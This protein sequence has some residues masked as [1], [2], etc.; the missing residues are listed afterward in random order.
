MDRSRWQGIALF[1]F[2]PLV[3]FLYLQLP[4]GP[5]LSLALG[6]GL[7]IGHRFIAAPWAS[8][9][10]EKR[11]I[12]CGR[13]GGFTDRLEVAAGKTEWKLVAC[14]PAHA[15][16]SKQFFTFIDRRK[17]W[18]A[19]GIFVPLGILLVNTLMLAFGRPFLSHE[20]ARLIFRTIVALTVVLTSFAWMR[21]HASSPLRCPF[22]L[23]NLFLLGIGNI[24][25]VFRV[26][27]I[28][29]FALTLAYVL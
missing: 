27:G 11:C 3:L 18:I 2:I 20:G 5:G 10:S 8:R 26:V 28:W 25:W 24:L 13:A 4:L 9:W 15:E 29:W 6:F 23:H 17:P 14:R 22:P 12:W 16:R 19:L 7:M 21:I 1:A